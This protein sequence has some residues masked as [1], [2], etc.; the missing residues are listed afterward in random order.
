M[1]EYMSPGV[2]VEEVPSAVKP[3]AGVSTSTACFLGV[4]P[5]DINVPEE[6][7]N[8]DPTGKSKPDPN[9][10]E[11]D[12]RKAFILKPF[13]FYSE[14]E[15]KQKRTAVK[16]AKENLDKNQDATKTADL[17]KALRDAEADKAQAEFPAENM[18]PVL[19]TSFAQFTK[20]FGGF[21][22]DGVGEPSGDLRAKPPTHGFQ[23]RLAHAVYGFFD[24][25]GSRCY[26]MR[27]RTI[28]ELME[29][30][31][32]GILE[33]IDE[34]SLI[35]A[36]G[37]SDKI[38]QQNL[39]DHCV[40]LGSRFAI[41]DPPEIPESSDLTE[42]K[43]RVVESTD[44]GALYF[45]RIRVFDIAARLTRA[46]IVDPTKAG[47]VDN[48]E[49]WLG[50]SGHIAGI[51]SRVDHQRGVHKAPANE[52]VRG[53]RDLE[54]QISKNDQDGLNP[55]GVNCI[56]YINNNITVW[57]ARTIGGDANTDLKYIN[58]RRTLIFLR[59]SIDRGT[60][61]VVFEPNDR[62]LWAKIRLNVSAFL[63]TVWRDGALFGST[64]QE[65]FYVKC[66][67]DTNPREERDLG[68]V[69]TEIGVAIVRPA[70]FVI[71]RISQWAGPEGQK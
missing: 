50:P 2:Y 15:L 41:L 65:A 1:P 61:W 18:E 48:G 56:R 47:E 21:S 64:P 55:G 39:I 10:P 11:A 40:K 13:H 29:S 23:N 4:V 45:P 38:V 27:F 53:A 14:D 22:D 30:S 57:G 70:E 51:Y 28:D 20:R 3:I 6:N 52:V 59:E 9:H 63:T 17:V 26:V 62:T 33:A 43:I 60:Q 66:D 5:D 71:F 69:I 16:T 68:R 24:N 44:Y 19:C 67:D 46:E 35:A 12:P 32:L 8:Y 37:I 25:G 31:H 36:P 34:I 42:E 7:T 49:I 54:F 58:V